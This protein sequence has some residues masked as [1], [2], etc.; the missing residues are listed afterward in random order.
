MFAELQSA[1][2]RRRRSLLWGILFA[3]PG[4]ASEVEGEWVQFP[5]YTPECY[6]QKKYYCGKPHGEIW[7]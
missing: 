7:K 5:E 6:E 3:A 1:E 4:V 2:D